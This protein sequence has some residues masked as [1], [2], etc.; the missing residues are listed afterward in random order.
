[1]SS[2]PTMIVGLRSAG[3]GTTLGR[4]RSPFR[5]AI[6][7]PAIV[8]LL[9]T[10]ATAVTT[11]LSNGHIMGALAPLLIGAALWFVW[12][13]PL[14]V[15]IAIA[16]VIGLSVDKMGDADNHWHSPFVMVGSALFQNLD[17][18]VPIDVLKFSAVFLI[19]ALLLVVRVYRVLIGRSRDTEG[20]L[21]PASPM[22]WAFGAALV[23]IGVAVVAGV[24]QGGDF[25]DAKVQ[26][27]AFLQLI[28]VAYLLSVSLRGP[29]DYRSLG[30][31]IVFAA[32]I[33]AVLAVWLRA[34]LP[35]E[36]PDSMGVMRE[37][38]YVTSHG[39]SIV[40][41]AASAAL[42]GPLFH[43][44]S[45]RHVAV[46][47][48]VMPIL[49]AGI[50]ANDRRIAW[51]EVGLVLATFI[52][53]NPGSIFTRRFA[54]MVVLMSPILAVYTLVGWQSASR[55][56]APIGLIRN[57]VQAERVDGSLDRSTLFRDLENF[58]L[59]YTFSMNPVV[60]IGFGRRFQTA[61]EEDELTD[62]SDYGFLPHN[63]VMGIWAFSGVV[64][65]TGIFSTIIVGFFLA[66]RAHARA[67]TAGQA[68]SAAAA[69]GLLLSYLVQLWADI[70]F[71]EAPTIFVVG[72]ALAIAA[73]MATATGAWPAHWRGQDTAQVLR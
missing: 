62:F 11:V 32:F 67:L 60:G 69:I 5:P 8:M 64:G 52:V 51:V 49:I 38:E 71:T 47:F 58:N 61:V 18:V 2:P 34:I 1:M 4:G 53:M 35:P 12:T 73:Q 59:V 14:R 39:D 24:I 28:G 26:V 36:Y 44:P 9:L 63:S 19:V 27:Q 31:M 15:T 40:F 20:S 66:A 65:F 68:M 33:K 21:A 46:F 41:A 16:M 25:Q 17:K 6:T 23:G 42:F 54:R 3:P 45:R 48:L 37:L 55:V 50:W 13:A 10:V 56:F 30:T 72:I 57:I 7:V 29:G 70:G 22:L 43:Q